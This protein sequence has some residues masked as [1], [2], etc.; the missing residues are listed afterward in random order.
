MVRKFFEE[1]FGF[2]YCTF[3]KAICSRMVRSYESVVN[4]GFGCKVF[5][6]LINKFMAIISFYNLW[7]TKGKKVAG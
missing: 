6:E 4:I 7:E 1:S 5:D 3:S 2:L